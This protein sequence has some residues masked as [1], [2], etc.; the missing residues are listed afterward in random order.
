MIAKY[1]PTNT[2]SE[3]RSILR[4][5]GIND[6]VT[7]TVE[8]MK[9]TDELFDDPDPDCFPELTYDAFK[10]RVSFTPKSDPDVHAQLGDYV[11]KG[12]SGGIY[13]FSPEIFERL[14]KLQTS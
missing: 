10:R 3:V 9:V 5:A 6:E 1:I 11:V 14:F 2:P 13:F 8:A 4:T 12:A 7:N